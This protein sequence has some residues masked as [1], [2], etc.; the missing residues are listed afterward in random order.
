M[1][2]KAVTVE[3]IGMIAVMKEEAAKTIASLP[4]A[5]L[6]TVFVDVMAS[7]AKEMSKQESRKYKRSLEYYL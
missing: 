3:V 2:D 4:V 6:L 7:T 5:L 1:I